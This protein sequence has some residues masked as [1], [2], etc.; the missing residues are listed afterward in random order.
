M[1][2]TEMSLEKIIKEFLFE[3]L[4][5]C[6]IMIGLRNFCKQNNCS[7]QHF[8]KVYMVLIH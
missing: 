2:K 3:I 8:A 5:I 4:I 6:L 7:T 1:F